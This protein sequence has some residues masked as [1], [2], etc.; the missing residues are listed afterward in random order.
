MTTVTLTINEETISIIPQTINIPDVRGMNS[1]LQHEE[2]SCTFTI[3]FDEEVLAMLVNNQDV[4]AHVYD[5]ENIVFSGTINGDIQWTEN[6][7]PEPADK[8]S[9]TIKDNTSLLDVPAESEFAMIG[10]TLSDIAQEICRI[11]G[12]NYSAVFTDNPKIAVFV[13]DKDKKY[14]DA[15]SN[16]LYQYCYTFFFDGSGAFDVVKLNISSPSGSLDDSDFLAGLNISKNKINYN[17]V[18][19]S[20]GTLTKK[21][22][23]QVYFEGNGLDS[24][25]RVLPITVRPGQY[26]PYDSDPVQEAREGKVYQNFESGYAESYT[27][28]SGET[29]Y[30]RT[31][32][33]T[34]VYTEN[35][36]VVRD[37]TGNI[38][39]HRTEFGARSAAVR[40]LNNGSSDA[41]LMQFAIR[42]D[43]YYRTADGVV[44]VGTG[45]KEYTCETEYIFDEATASKLA[46]LLY[47]INTGNSLQFSGKVETAVIPGNV[48]AIDTG[49]S[50]IK[51][52]AIALSCIYDSETQMYTST[53]LSVSSISI[54]ITK[55]KNR[56]SSNDTEPI[57]KSIKILAPQGLAFT[58]KKPASLKLSV[59]ASGFIPS[60]YQW[61]K[62]ETAIS[63]E[64]ASSLT[65]TQEGIYKVVVNDVFF[66]SVTVIAVENGSDGAKGK[67]GTNGTNGTNTWYSSVSATSATSSIAISTITSVAGHTVGV[68]DLIVANSLVFLVTSV[69]STTVTVSYK[70]SIKGETGTRA[71]RYLGK[72]S[73]AP[74]SYITGD[75]YLKTTDGGVYY[76]TASGWSVITWTDTTTEPDYRLLACMEDILV[77]IETVKTNVTMNNLVDKY[78][79]TLIA[80]QAFINK[81]RAKEILFQKY[82]GSQQNN[83]VQD[84]DQL[85]SMGKNPVDDTDD[86]FSFLI[87]KRIDGTWKKRFWSNFSGDNI[88]M[89]LTGNINVD[90][91][92]KTNG[93]YSWSIENCTQ[94]SYIPESA[95][96]IND[97]SFLVT[98][99]TTKNGYYEIA[100]ELRKLETNV[101]P[102]FFSTSIL[103]ESNMRFYKYGTSVYITSHD[104]SS[105][106]YSDGSVDTSNRFTKIYSMVYFKGYI[107]ARMA[108]LVLR[109]SPDVLLDSSVSVKNWSIVGSTITNALLTTA[110]V[111]SDNYLYVLGQQGDQ[112]YSSN[113]YSWTKRKVSSLVSYYFIKGI[114]DETQTDAILTIAQ[115]ELGRI[116]PSGSVGYTSL[117]N[118]TGKSIY[119]FIFFNGKLILVVGSSTIISIRAYKLKGN[120]L[121]LEKETTINLRPP[122]GS[123]WSRYNVHFVK[124]LKTL[125]LATLYAGSFSSFDGIHWNRDSFLQPAPSITSDFSLSYDNYVGLICSD[126]S[127]VG[128][129][130]SG[131]PLTD[132]GSQMFIEV[133]DALYINTCN[134]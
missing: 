117:L 9:I 130:V 45:N 10:E 98:Y 58:N 36:S 27:T 121:T 12:I 19:V 95:I 120:T 48:Y 34:L 74:T 62:D 20:Y 102:N 46:Q 47:R 111:Q 54:A 65:I 101:I 13:I 37:W 42:A 76:R 55:Y 129:L 97:T 30:R 80:N 89:N 93:K 3:P 116:V 61:Y 18:K 91:S 87:Q 110:L 25:N 16:L 17:S 56:F 66:D 68:G 33:S 21:N 14:L 127:S 35:H 82:V 44:K 51:T 118:V 79:D 5:S 96:A 39:I 29:K 108:T 112:W 2:Q 113:G 53:L 32:K 106:T 28:Y 85:I 41:S 22:N 69:N 90:G 73:S 11:C 40:L 67:D 72:Y 26:Y 15:F 63:G 77:L 83:S 38:T 86:N 60:S 114:K 1:S 133:D 124:T 50:G 99:W 81:L 64:T 23:E 84:G 115:D 94:N 131:K 103:E 125:Y 126:G 134:N 109:I 59:E 24:E 71:I 49:T 132:L 52:T 70:S 104:K 8:I 75:W 57:I 4:E 128:Y 31:S 119:D 122:T 105:I 6:G 78:I 43:A 107:Y 123:S 92:I 7:Y 100:C 88:D